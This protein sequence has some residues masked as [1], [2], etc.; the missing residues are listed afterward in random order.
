MS[1]EVAER[2]FEP[3]F[4]TKGPGK[5]SGLGLASV[6]GF[7]RQS[8]GHAT[9]YSEIGKGTTVRIYLPR[10]DS[11]DGTEPAARREEPM[12]LGQGEMVLAVEDDANVRRLTVQRL[13]AL[14]Y[15]VH[16]VG[17]ANAALKAI[18]DGLK[19][20]VVFTDYM[21]PGGV[22]GLELAQRLRT[23]HPG[24]AVLLTTGYAGGL[25]DDRETNALRI[26]VLMKPYRQ[27]KLAQAIREAI[28][29][30]GAAR[31]PSATPER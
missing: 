29:S 9:L 6:Y 3:F 19:P 25:I 1:P 13:A 21:M 7:A 20:V 4:T 12:L 26:R 17:D 14:G 28:D 10:A 22:S 30:N 15:E 2:A 27:A 5:G 11:Y 18:A 24:I 16:A 31:S 23:S 8:G